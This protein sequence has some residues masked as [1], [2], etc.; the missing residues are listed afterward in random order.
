MMK[1]LFYLAM[2]G[3]LLTACNNDDETLDIPTPTTDNYDNGIIVLNEGALKKVLA[4][5]S[6]I[7]P[8]GKVENNIYRNNNAN[9]ILGDVLQGITFYKDK[10]F[11]VIN[12]SNKVV[13]V[14]RHNFKKLAVITKNLSLPRYATVSRDKLYVT[15]N[16]SKSVNVYDADTYEFLETLPM[17]NSPEDI[18]SKDN[19][20]Y[21]MLASYGSGNKIMILDSRTNNKKD[22]IILDKGSLRGIKFNSD[23]SNLYAFCAPR[24]GSHIFQISTETNKVTKEWATTIEGTWTSKMAVDKNQVYFVGEGKNVYH[25]DP[26]KDAVDEN[27]IVKT[28]IDKSETYVYNFYGFNVI[29][30]KIYNGKGNFAGDSKIDVYNLK[31]EKTATYTVGNGVSGFIKNK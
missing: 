11:L 29:D 4:E 9:E 21:V 7:S 5:V 18:I 17:T 24:E 20:V 8:N 27:P 19:T 30:E 12:N 10:A 1:K 15:N 16:R 25:L 13:V 23:K 6:Y 22:S 2:F 31:G 14:D 26:T 3:L 28:T